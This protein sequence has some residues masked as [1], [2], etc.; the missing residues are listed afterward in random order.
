[1]SHQRYFASAF[2]LVATFV[3]FCAPSSLAQG[4]KKIS[5]K[6][7]PAPVKASFQKAYPAAKI[8]GASTEVEN[9]TTQFEIESV[10]G[11]VNRDL[12]YAP[13][14]TCLEIEESIPVSALPKEVSDS[15]HKEFPKGTV[16]K[17]E[18]LQKG[19]TTLYELVIRSGKSKSEVVFDP[20]GKILENTKKGTKEKKDKED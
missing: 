10:D 12:L 5:I 2:L 14:G 7:L 3:L 6:D 8:R 4:E 15:L 17:S 9:G 1:M 18:K 20:T 19:A 13:D 11:K 16:M